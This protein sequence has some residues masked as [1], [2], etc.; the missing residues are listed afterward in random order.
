MNTMNKRYLPDIILFCISIILTGCTKTTAAELTPVTV[1]LQWI[2]QAQFA[3]LYAADQNGYYAEEG[4]AV[5]FVPGGSGVDSL[6]PLVDGSAQFGTATADQ[7]LLARVEG[8]F[9]KAFAVIYRRSPAVFMALKSSGITR[10][11]DFVGKTIRLPAPNAPTLHAMMANL[12]IS[13]NQYSEVDLPSDVE[14]FAS[15]RVPVWGAYVNALAISVQRAGHEINIIYPDDYGVHFYSD[16]LIATDDF[17]ANNPDLVR[18]FLRASLKGW[19]FA[20]EN[21]EKVGPMVL[22]YLPEADPELE[23]AKMISSIPLVN[24][25]ED[26]IGWMKPEVWAAMEKILREQG[27]IINP[28]D[29]EQA[30]TAQFLEEI[31]NK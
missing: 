26:F 2:H 28:L 16:T 9:V 7:I 14:E 22:K 12:G 4:L 23:N 27:L 30:Y 8:K 19:T 3:G 5:T 10:P 24:T 6:Q 25:G 15:G 20:V 29:V 13:Q 17:I 1:Q 31:Y 18:R 11:Q 21:P